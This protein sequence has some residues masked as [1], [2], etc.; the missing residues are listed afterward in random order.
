[1]EEKEY[2]HKCRRLIENKLNWGNSASW[3]TTDFEKLSQKILD[4]TNIMLSTSTLKRIWGKVKYESSPNRATLDALVQF[5]GHG[6]W[7]EFMNADVEETQIAK[8]DS[9][10][11]LGQKGGTTKRKWLIAVSLLS[12]IIFLMFSLFQKPDNTLQFKNVNFSVKSVGTGLP[13]TVIFNYDA[14]NSNADSVFIQLSWD[15]TKRFRVDKH[16]HEYSTTYYYPGYYRAKLILNDSIVKE[17]DVFIET[18]GWVKIINHDPVPIYLPNNRDHSMGLNSEEF[19]ALNI[20]IDKNVP[21]FSI[22]KVQKDFGIMGNNFEF[23]AEIQNTSQKSNAVCQHT[24]ILLMGINGVI[25]VPFCKLGCVGEIGLMLG[26]HYI[27]GKTHDLS[28]FGVDF[29]QPIQFKCHVA[30]QKISF[31]VDNTEVY[32]SD[33]SYDIG[34]IVGIQ[35][36]FS[37]TGEVTDVSLH[38]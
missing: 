28:G 13:R 17:Q 24:R 9:S 30:N 6:N 23:E 3:Q 26:M 1:M 27:D 12:L 31:L 36:E 15:R 18:E 37:G 25:G 8:H 22:T 4:E 34:K 7:L 21:V 29:S 14:N 16:L 2:I 33:F 32:S 35:I 11:K 38:N 20:D 5:L 10:Q 19:Q